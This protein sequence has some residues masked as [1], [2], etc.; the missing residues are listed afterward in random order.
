MDDDALDL[1]TTREAAAILR[2]SVRS[3]ERLHEDGR[4]PPRVALSPRRYGYA[5]SAVRAWIT[6]RTVPAKHAA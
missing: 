1:L 3:L 2:I 6:A 5:R 4:G